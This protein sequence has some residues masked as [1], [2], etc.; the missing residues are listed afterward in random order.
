MEKYSTLPKL[1]KGRLKLSLSQEVCSKTRKGDG[2][3]CRSMEYQQLPDT[4]IEETAL[5]DGRPSVAVILS[6]VA[7]LAGSRETC[8]PAC[9]IIAASLGV[10]MV[11]T[12]CTVPVPDS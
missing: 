10:K 7:S 4:H 1:L 8:I 3:G 9:E 11:N 12:Q 5:I 2:E 6:A